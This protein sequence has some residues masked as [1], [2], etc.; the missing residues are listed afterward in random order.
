M[1]ALLADRARWPHALLLAGA[2]GIGKRVLARHVVRALL[3]ER[4]RPGGL[5]CGECDGC[6]YV[7]A[8][9]HPDLRILEPVE[10][11]EAGVEKRLDAIPVTQV[12]A[13]IDFVQLTS[14][15][16]G[17]KVALIAPAERMNPSAANA[18]LKTLEEP[19]ADTYLLL[20]AHQPGRLPA[21]IVSRCRRIDVPAPAADV[22]VGW[23]AAQ[24]VRDAANALAEAGGAPYAALAQSVLQAE[25][26]AWIAAL[27]EP[28]QLSAPALAARIDLASRDER[29]DRLA[30]AIDWL[31]A[32]TADLARVAAGGAPRRN[33]EA[34]AA[35]VALARQV[36][37]VP[38]SRYHRSLLR[39]RARLSHPLTPRL[40]A[41]AL[42]LEYQGL[43]DHGG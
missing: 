30:A 17:N 1:Q 18:L 14:H 19:P 15:R 43:F 8:G 7:A 12:R 16:R 41:E 42:L 25:R 9:Q 4:P 32:W 35:L 28:A 3:C 33:L 29:K 27:A 24:G 38:L 20:V 10:R 26:A 13:L 40:V 23:L 11:D 37:R 21:T 5:A 22:A 6:R 39:H 34:G 36:A 2:P 31:L